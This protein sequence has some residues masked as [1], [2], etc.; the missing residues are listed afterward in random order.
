MGLRLGFRLERY[1]VLRFGSLVRVM[2]LPPQI[3][4]SRQHSKQQHNRQEITQVAAAFG[5]AFF[6]MRHNTI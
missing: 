2:F 5:R 6:Q 3:T 4:G 1:L